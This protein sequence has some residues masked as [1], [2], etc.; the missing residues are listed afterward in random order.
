[1]H[2][3]TETRRCI[4]V[5]ESLNQKPATHRLKLQSSV[6]SLELQITTNFLVF[7]ARTEGN[8]S[9]SDEGVYWV[10]GR[11]AGLT[12]INDRLEWPSITGIKQNDRRLWAFISYRLVKPG[13]LEVNKLALTAD[14]QNCMCPIDSGENPCLITLTQDIGSLAWGEMGSVLGDVW[15]NV[16]TN[17]WR[18]NSLIAHVNVI[19]PRTRSSGH[20]RVCL[21]GDRFISPVQLLFQIIFWACMM[22]TNA[23]DVQGVWWLAMG[24]QFQKHSSL[25]VPFRNYIQHVSERHSGNITLRLDSGI[26]QVGFSD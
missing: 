25:L 6:I 12:P 5:S 18:E 2:H 22:N 3:A 19:K 15:E 26:W 14:D 13:S 1:M 8:A 20:L 9:Q 7:E 17:A 10:F 11:A 21:L 24:V 4:N 23:L 16:G